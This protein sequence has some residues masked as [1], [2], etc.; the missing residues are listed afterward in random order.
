MKEN[1]KALLPFSVWQLNDIKL[2]IANK[3]YI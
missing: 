1:R 2:K 3:L